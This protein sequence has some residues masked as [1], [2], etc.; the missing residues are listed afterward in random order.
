MKSE[1]SSKEI[2]FRRLSFWTIVAVYLLIL[3]GGVVRSTGAGMG[4]P[5]WPKCFGNWVP[6]SEVS[7]LPTDY[8]DIYS[9]KRA[10][11]NER[12]ATYLDFFGF[13][14]EADKIRNDKSILIEAEFNKS[15]TWTEY[16]NRV[17]GVII[18]FLIL[19]TFFAS[20]AW[21]KKDKLIFY[22]SFLALMLVILEGWIGS[23]VVSTNL[24]AWV[25]TVHMLLALA[26]VALLIYV[27]YRSQNIEITEYQVGKLIKNL[28]IA[29]LVVTLVQTVLGTQVREMVDRIA[30]SF[31]M[32]SR[33]M[34]I[35]ALG[36]PF[37]IHRSFSILVLGLHLWLIS[38]LIKGQNEEGE[39][40]KLAKWL[41]V[42]LVAEVG[43]GVIMAYFAIPATMQPIHLLLGSLAIGIQFM[44]LFKVFR[45]PKEILQNSVLA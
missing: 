36:L 13:Q 1:N 28:V 40:G 6:P 22:L 44:L 45:K 30:A 43:T 2:V 17:L 14:V 38:L 21:L 26:I 12:F 4:C 42:V 23:V 35:D 15:K 10:E 39:L 25:V 19:L 11:K 34:W 3:V 8:K 27:N 37:Y 24:T 16:L 31:N 5:D 41:L 32:G 29:C 20:R 33:D 18:G 7:E 9:A